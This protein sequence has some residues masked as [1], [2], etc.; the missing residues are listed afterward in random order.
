MTINKA[1]CSLVHMRHFRLLRL[2]KPVLVV[3]YAEKRNNLI[4]KTKKNIRAILTRSVWLLLPSFTVTNSKSTKKII[5][6]IQ[7]VKTSRFI[8]FFHVATLAGCFKHWYTSVN[9]VKRPEL[10]VLLMSIFLQNYSRKNFR[11]LLIYAT[12]RHPIITTNF[13]YFHLNIQFCI[14]SQLLKILLQWFSIK[15]MGTQSQFDRT[16][17]LQ[18]S[19]LKFEKSNHNKLCSHILDCSIFFWNLTA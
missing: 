15:N 1:I 11:E 16:I 3:I 10:H 13:Y 2:P 14:E 7:N 12:N 17:N 8:Y 6:I 4:F 18:N 5:W 19:K 9:H